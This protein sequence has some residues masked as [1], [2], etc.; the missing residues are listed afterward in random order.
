MDATVVSRK[1]DML[2]R[3]SVALLFAILEPRE[4]VSIGKRTE[5]DILLRITPSVAFDFR[6]RA[7]IQLHDAASET[8]AIHR[9]AH[10]AELGAVRAVFW[11]GPA[12]LRLVDYQQFQVG[13][14]PISRR[15][16]SGS[17]S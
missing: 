17:A 12:D 6:M 1:R 11:P 7:P 13:W 10:R 9:H 2:N 3:K 4:S 15:T 5:Q 16:I 14:R 8:A